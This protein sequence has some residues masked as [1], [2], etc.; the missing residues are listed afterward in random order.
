[1]ALNAK[2]YTLGGWIKKCNE[3]KSGIQT[4]GVGGWQAK[5]GKPKLDEMK[6]KIAEAF[7]TGLL[8]I[9]GLTG[10]LEKSI[11][12]SVSRLR[13]ASAKK[14][15][16]R[17]WYIEIAQALGH[18]VKLLAE[19]QGEIIRAELQLRALPLSADAKNETRIVVLEDFEARVN[20]AHSQIEALY[21]GKGD[22]QRPFLPSKCCA[23]LA[24]LEAAEAAI[25]AA[26]GSPT[27]SL[28]GAKGSDKL[29]AL[30]AKLPAGPVV[31]ATIVAPSGPRPSV[32][33][34]ASP[35]YIGNA[36]NA[37]RARLAVAK[38]ELAAHEELA[39]VTVSTLEERSQ[40]LVAE[41]AAAQQYLTVL[42]AEAGIVEAPAPSKPSGD[43]DGGKKKA[44]KKVAA[45]KT[46]SKK[47]GSKAHGANGVVEHAPNN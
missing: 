35:K 40:V 21:A 17:S 32:I 13:R 1:M 45:K 12:E 6:D 41:A 24:E 44:A 18:M 14:D 46:P 19:R 20:N 4:K 42:L 43:D 15:E 26:Q 38:L 39:A 8:E 31:A 33:V 47:G 11:A 30:R 28:A 22:G 3:I 9:L 29:A 36:F 5:A 7:I 23:S 27:V 25:K 16:E 10:E 2:I 37:A 34:E